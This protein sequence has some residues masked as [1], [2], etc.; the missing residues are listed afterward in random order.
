MLAK[1]RLVRE[2]VTFACL[3]DRNIKA[4]GFLEAYQQQFQSLALKS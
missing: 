3:W 4:Q 2:L 1:P